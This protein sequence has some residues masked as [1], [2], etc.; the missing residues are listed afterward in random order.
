MTRLN[1]EGSA[2]VYSTFLG[3]PAGDSARGLAVDSLEN[4]YLTGSTDS[5]NFPVTSGAYDTTYNGNL[6]IFAGRMA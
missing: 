2:L 5:T 1:A 3:G 6:D 4:V